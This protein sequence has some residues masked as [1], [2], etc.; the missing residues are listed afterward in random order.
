MSD[1]LVNEMK[2]PLV[3]VRAFLPTGTFDAKDFSLEVCNRLLATHNLCDW[4]LLYPIRKRHAELMRETLVED[5]ENDL[6]NNPTK[7]ICPSLIV[8]GMLLN[9]SGYIGK[10]TKVERYENI[11]NA[12]EPFTYLVFMEYVCGD[13]SMH[14][15]FTQSINNGTAKGYLSTAQGNRLATFTLVETST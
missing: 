7:S 12:L 15:F 13:L 2:D 14:H 8:S 10:V 4:S 6:L 5:N 9:N 11:D 3:Q 1:K